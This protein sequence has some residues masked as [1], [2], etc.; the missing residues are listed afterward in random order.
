MHPALRRLRE[1]ERFKKGRPRGKKTEPMSEEGMEMMDR[2]RDA[3]TF[4][5]VTPNQ[6]MRAI[7]L[8]TRV[9][10]RWARNGGEPVGRTDTQLSADVLAAALDLPTQ[11]LQVDG[12]WLWREPPDRV[13]RGGA[14]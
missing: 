7:G 10:Y 2:L 13:G 12:P 4:R 6:L 11:Y 8:D 3:C 14:S 5:R 9:L 1:E